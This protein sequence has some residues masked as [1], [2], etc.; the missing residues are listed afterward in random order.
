MVLF[1]E[2][3]GGNILKNNIVVGPAMV[4]GDPAPL[5]DTTGNIWVQRD[6]SSWFKNPSIGDLHLNAIATQAI[7]QGLVLADVPNDFDDKPRDSNPDIGAD[8]YGNESVSLPWNY[9]A[10]AGPYGFIVYPNPFSTG[11]TIN[12]KFPNAQIP[13]F[14]NLNISIYDI[15]GQLVDQ[16]FSFGKLGNSGFGNSYAWYANNQPNGIYIFKLETDR[17]VLTRSAVLRK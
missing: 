8:E 1:F 15:K 6:I 7:D 16:F 5:P 9:E 4:Y 3:I 14:P 17:G 2:N 12:A 13:K 11:V 10:P